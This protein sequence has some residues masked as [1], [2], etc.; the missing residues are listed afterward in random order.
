MLP[1]A[2]KLSRDEFEELFRTGTR[3]H[4]DAFSLI[5]RKTTSLPKGA[6]VVPKKVVSGIVKRNLIK[7]RLYKAMRDNLHMDT[8]LLS[9]KDIEDKTYEELKK[10]YETLLSGVK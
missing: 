5:Y 10:E 4:G 6:V 1:K 2:Q 9:K 3:I 7:R 8:I